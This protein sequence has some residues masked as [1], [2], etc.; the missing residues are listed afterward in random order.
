MPA[1]GPIQTLS[2]ELL[3][4]LQIQVSCMLLRWHSSINRLINR[5]QVREL[6]IRLHSM[7][8]DALYSTIF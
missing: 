5:T 3:T 2:S 1:Y 4:F 8:R 6:L 7:L